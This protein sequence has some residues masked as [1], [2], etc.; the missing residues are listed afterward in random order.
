MVLRIT[1][2][3]GIFVTVPVICTPASTGVRCL[4]HSIGIPVAKRL[5]I[6]R[7]GIWGSNTRLAG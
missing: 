3:P 5:N 7:A 2:G 6:R 1:A 4:G